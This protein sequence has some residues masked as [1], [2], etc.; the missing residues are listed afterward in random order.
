MPGAERTHESEYPF[1]SCWVDTRKHFSQTY[2]RVEIRA[3]FPDHS[4]PGVWPQHWMLPVPE[5]AVPR[6]AC[7]PVGGEIDI[8]A[9]RQNADKG[10]KS[11]EGLADAFDIGNV[12]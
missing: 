2:G 8:A 9:I 11:G 4:C 6:E 12:I 7:W 1:V 3:Q 5:T 10:P